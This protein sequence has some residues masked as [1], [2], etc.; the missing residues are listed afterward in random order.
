VT[1]EKGISKRLTK[2]LRYE[3]IIDESEIKLKF[4]LV[5]ASIFWKLG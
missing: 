3:K 2:K 1:L 4:Q 5:T